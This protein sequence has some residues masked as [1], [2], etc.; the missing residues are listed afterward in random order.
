MLA[1]CQIVHKDSLLVSIVVFYSDTSSTSLAFIVHAISVFIL[2]DIVALRISIG[3]SSL[4]CL[5]FPHSST[6]G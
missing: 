1:F 5:A 3:R 6:V 4:S 2:P